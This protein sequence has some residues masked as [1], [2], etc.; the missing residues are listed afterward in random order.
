ML[1]GL[2]D[3]VANHFIQNNPLPEE[4][5]EEL[6]ARFR[7]DLPEI[8]TCAQQ[9]DCERVRSWLE[10][11]IAR[12]GTHSCVDRRYER[13]GRNL[14]HEAALHGQKKMVDLLCDEFGA[15][16]HARTVMGK[17]TALHLAASRNH[18]QVCFW[19]ISVYGAEP[20]MRN[21]YNWTPLHYAA[22][23]AS[24]NT[25]KC[26]V[27]YGGRT[28]HKNDDGHTPVNLAMQ[29]GASDMLIDFLLKTSEEHERTAFHEDLDLMRRQ[30][31]EEAAIR[32]KEAKFHGEAKARAVLE[33]ARLEYERWRSGRPRTPP[34]LS[35]RPG[36]GQVQIYHPSRFMGAG[37]SEEA[38]Q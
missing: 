22:Q 33:Q 23:Y 37:T 19:L 28:I 16:V 24:M 18:R 34:P 21:K 20:N 31:Q 35:P 27:R 30:Q 15:N 6:R 3:Q 12:E 26:I 11:T 29:R 5:L 13:T 2:G 10:G 14:L 17:D 1:V 4:R 25:V 38:G 32:E 7:A 8:F 36:Y 9:G